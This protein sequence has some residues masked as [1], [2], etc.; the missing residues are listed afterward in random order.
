MVD[1]ISFVADVMKLKSAFLYLVLCFFCVESLQAQGGY[2]YIEAEP[3][4]PFYLRTSD[5]LVLSSPGNFL[6]LA[7]LRYWGGDITVGFQ[8][9]AQPVFQFTVRDTLEEGSYILKSSPDG[10]RLIDARKNM[11][12]SIRRLGR[13]EQQFAHLR[14]REDPFAYR[15]SQV[16]NDSSILYYSPRSARGTA[17]AQASTAKQM[18]AK[19]KPVEE[20]A[21]VVVEKPKPVEEK[22]LPTA[23]KAPPIA[24]K[25]NQGDE[26]V[27]LAGEKAKQ[28]EEKA[29]STD[30]IIKLTEEKKTTPVSTETL[31]IEKP[32]A[33]DSAVLAKEPTS[34]SPVPGINYGDSGLYR[35]IAVAPAKPAAPADTKRDSSATDPKVEKKGGILSVFSRKN[36]STTAKETPAVPAKKEAEAGVRRLFK[37]D[38]GS[39]WKLIYEVDDLGKKDTIE[40]NIIKTPV[41][42]NKKGSKP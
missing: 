8:G 29:K 38:M 13:N 39:S 21:A 1:F 36:N 6:I 28:A 20:K 26:K 30:E 5:S 14:K 4:T 40:V 24:E 37:T 2:L 35:P 34:T 23:E 25:V 32:P 9:Q 10:W 11:T 16:V 15:L 3:S 7:P 33:V 42:K 22:A 17:I 27:S 19:G 12:I 31:A 41:G 18:E